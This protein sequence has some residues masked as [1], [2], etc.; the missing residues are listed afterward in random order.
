MVC[1]WSIKNVNIYL[2]FNVHTK[3]IIKVTHTSKDTFLWKSRNILQRQENVIFLFLL[4]ICQL[5]LPGL[6]EFIINSTYS[7]ISRLFYTCIV[8]EVIGIKFHNQCWGYKDKEDR[9]PAFK[10]L[11]VHGRCNEKQD[12]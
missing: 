6:K 12:G 11:T 3:Q 9:L 7:F 2:L 4:F 8:P 1:S 5:V 10:E